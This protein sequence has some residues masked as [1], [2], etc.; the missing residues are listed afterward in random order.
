VPEPENWTV[1]GE[2][3]ALL[4]TTTLPEA[5]PVAAGANATAKDVAWPDERTRGSARPV[6]LKPVPLTL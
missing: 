3:V 2:F 6:T 4:L 1:A 5:L